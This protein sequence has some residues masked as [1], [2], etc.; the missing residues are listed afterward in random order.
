MVDV[1]CN[2]M[3]G[4]GAGS[5]ASPSA[6][7]AEHPGAGLVLAGACSRDLASTALLF[8]DLCRA[9]SLLPQAEARTGRGHTKVCACR[10]YEC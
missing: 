4:C 5:R 7:L 8:H 2:G 10:E 1:L 6:R 9:A 3:I